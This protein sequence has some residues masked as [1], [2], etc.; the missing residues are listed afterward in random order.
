MN[1]VH[2]MN[3]TAGSAVVIGLLGG[4]LQAGQTASR[5][6]TEWGLNVI[7]KEDPGRFLVR[8]WQA[9]EG[10]P[11]D[12]I[13]CLLQTRD[14]CLWAG[15]PEGVIRF[16]GA[17]PALINASRCAAFRSEVCKALA[18][19]TRGGLWIATKKG[20]VQFSEGKARLFL[21]AD[22]LGGDETTSRWPDKNGGMWV[23]TS[24]AGIP[25]S[26]C[27]QPATCLVLLLSP[28]DQSPEAHL[29]KL[30]AIAQRFRDPGRIERLRVAA[31]VAEAAAALG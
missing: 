22:G 8:R 27:A 1:L 9:K 7:R 29:R 17:N 13:E 2:H 19:D 3:W 28:T 31:T 11:A 23:G 14:G 10:F 6:D 30:A 15:T 12:W 5:P 20:V 16:D 21:A 24:Q 26:G 18:E 25:V 4:L